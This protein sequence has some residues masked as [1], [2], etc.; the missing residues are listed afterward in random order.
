M[1]NKV[2]DRAVK[3]QEVRGIPAGEVKDWQKVD[4]H[5]AQKMNLAN[6]RDRFSLSSPYSQRLIF[7]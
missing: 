3:H 6:H 4:G 7:Y 1:Q 2:V 5:G